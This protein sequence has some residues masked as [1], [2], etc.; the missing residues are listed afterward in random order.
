[1][2]FSNIRVG[3]IHTPKIKR[4]HLVDYYSKKNTTTIPSILNVEP[5]K[6]TRYLLIFPL[7]INLTVSAE[8][9]IYG[10]VKKQK[11]WF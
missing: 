6:I 10:L 7:K 9:T 4:S 8:N 2:K 11:F 5:I 1:M 3:R